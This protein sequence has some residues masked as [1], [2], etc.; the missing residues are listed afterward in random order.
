MST[1][2]NFTRDRDYVAPSRLRQI[3]KDYSE[4]MDHDPEDCPT[5]A[6][7][8]ALDELLS[9]RGKEGVPVVRERLDNADPDYVFGLNQLASR[10]AFTNREKGFG[11][12]SLENIDRKLLLAVSEICE[13]QDVLRDGHAPDSVFWHP[14]DPN[15][16]SGPVG[17]IENGDKPDG[18]SIE[19]ADAIIRL[20]HICSALNI[21][22]AAAVALKVKY[23][24]TRPEKHGRI[25]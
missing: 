1:N 2:S 11:D 20:L 14:K 10:I 8:W 7:Y 13:A 24:R 15:R 16:T 18:F 17:S 22:I 3:Q 21:D 9:R 12:P 5:A 23:N 4:H 25:F 6:L 19:L